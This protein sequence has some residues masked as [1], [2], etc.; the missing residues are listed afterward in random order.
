LSNSDPKPRAIFDGCYGESEVPRALAEELWS[1]E[2]S[3]RGGSRLL[4]RGRVGKGKF[5]DFIWLIYSVFFIVD[6]I[7][8][9]N[10]G[11]WLEFAAAYTCFL[12]LYTGL[13]YAKRKRTQF[14]VL[15]AMGL[16]GI[17][18]FPFNGGACGMF[19]Y[20][21]AFVPFIAESIPVSVITFAAVSG[22]MM[23]VGVLRIFRC[24]C[25]IGE[26]GGCAAHA[27]EQKTGACA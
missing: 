27:R 9:H 18:Y 26:S 16:L 2:V 1:A 20:V 11:V 8:R 12:A 23:V 13:V 19:I 10:A 7:Q 5:S 22:I 21:A 25:G 24:R 6:P 4:Q 15:I 17:A 3:L 14:V